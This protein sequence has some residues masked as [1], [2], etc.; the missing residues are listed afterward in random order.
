M[1]LRRSLLKPFLP[2]PFVVFR[3]RE[4]LLDVDPLVLKHQANDEAVVVA[5]DVENREIAHHV[6]RRKRLPNILDVFPFGYNGRIEPNLQRGLGIGKLRRS[7][8]EAPLA[9]DV[10]N[11]MLAKC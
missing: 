8:Q 2:S 3:V 10:H 6:C 1:R 11:S 7:F 5:T 4:E 9:Y